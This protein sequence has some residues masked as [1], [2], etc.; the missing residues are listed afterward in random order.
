V[1]GQHTM[2]NG[3]RE[4]TMG[5]AGQAFELPIRCRHCEREFQVRANHDAHD[6]ATPYD[7]SFRSED[8][9]RHA[10]QEHRAA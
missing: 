5:R 3:P 8:E 2:G 6:C 4:T 10:A 1:S 9:A 7:T